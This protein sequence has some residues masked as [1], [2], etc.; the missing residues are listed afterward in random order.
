MVAAIVI[1]VVLGEVRIA[2]DM[3]SSI[4]SNKILIYT[5]LEKSGKDNGAFKNSITTIDQVIAKPQVEEE[6]ID[7]KTL[8]ENER[9]AAAGSKK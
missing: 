7:E 2:I 6:K 8:A 4:Q 5:D 9:K 1:S 3:I